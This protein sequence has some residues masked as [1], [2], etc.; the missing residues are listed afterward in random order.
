MNI[1]NVRAGEFFGDDHSARFVTGDDRWHPLLSLLRCAIG[2]QQVQNH[3]ALQPHHRRCRP[4]VAAD[5]FH[6]AAKT[7]GR[8]FAAAM[9]FCCRHSQHTDVAH[10]FNDP[11]REQRVLIDSIWKDKLAAVTLCFGNHRIACRDG[12]F[13]LLVVG[14]DFVDGKLPGEQ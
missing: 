3:A 10:P 4:A 5:D 2:L 9:F 14:H 8:H 11:R 13:R 1:I 12:S 6:N 7:G